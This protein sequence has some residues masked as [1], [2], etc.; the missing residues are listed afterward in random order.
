MTMKTGF[1]KRYSDIWK[2]IS[3]SLITVSTTITGFAIYEDIKWL[4]YTALAT[5][6]LGKLALNIAEYFAKE[7]R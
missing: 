2:L 6:I 5:L 7:E 1:K 4:G 3:D